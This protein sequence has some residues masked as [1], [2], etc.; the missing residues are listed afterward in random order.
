[1]KTLKLN[2]SL[3]AIAAAGI[4]AGCSTTTPTQPPVGKPPSVV[5]GTPANPTTTPQ[6]FTVT[7]R[8]PDGYADILRVYFLINT[9][10]VTG[11]N[12]C[13]GYYERPSNTLYLYDDA[14]VN[15]TGPL[16]PGSPSTLQNSQCIV[17]GSSSS[18]VS[19]TGTDVTL[20]IGLGLKRGYSAS[21]KKVY[22]WVKDNENHDTGWVKTGTWF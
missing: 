10:P 18:L 19:A 17:Y 8:D 9:D 16:A 2:L 20:N 12:I 7:G 1:M 22:F 4:L 15:A 13:H 3:L 6:T 11:P 5:S 21:Q 14:L